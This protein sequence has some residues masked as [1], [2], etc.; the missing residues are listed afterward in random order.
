MN[1]TTVTENEKFVAT[2]EQLVKILVAEWDQLVDSL[3]RWCHCGNDLAEEA[4]SELKCKLLGAG[5][6]N[7]HV[8]DFV[9]DFA[10]REPRDVKGHCVFLA[11][12]ARARISCS[13]KS[14]RSVHMEETEQ[15]Y[16]AYLLKAIPGIM[17]QHS[18]QIDESEKES[19]RIKLRE[20]LY[21]NFAMECKEHKVKADNASA[22]KLNMFDE[23]SINEAVETV[24]KNLDDKEFKA[25]CNGLSQSK[26]RMFRYM[27][28][29]L[30]EDPVVREYIANYMRDML[31]NNKFIQDQMPAV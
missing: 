1:N 30:T 9:L 7:G 11:H 4:L 26:N 31:R 2:R 16:Q 8:L 23:M 17:Q 12:Q 27:R 18:N 3:T 5:I 13:R 6:G 19:A 29:K 21:K 14:N 10:T 28:E 15:D 22:C 24:W 20:S 25:K